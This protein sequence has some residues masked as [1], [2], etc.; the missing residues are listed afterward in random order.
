[1]KTAIFVLSILMLLWIGSK[2]DFLFGKKESI[3]VKQ[4]PL[5]DDQLLDSVQYLT[6]Q[7]FWKGSE[8]NSG[9]APERIHMNNVY[10]E[11]DKHIIATGG[12]GFGIMGMLA[13]CERGFISRDQLLNRL[14]QVVSFLEKAERFHGAYPHW[15]NGE[16]GK[17]KPFTPKDNGGD[18]VETAYLFQGLLAV[19]QYYLTGESREKLMGKRKDKLWR[20]VEWKWYQNRKPVLYW[21]WSPNYGWEMNFPIEGYNECLIAYVLGASSPTYPIS[22]DAYHK[23]WARNGKIVGHHEKYGYTLVLNHNYS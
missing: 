12:S 8:P 4:H 21:H 13:A 5:T 1:M 15:I 16:T 20:E 2:N 7:Y 6:F 22:P 19:K 23:G 14:T 10:P 18:I 17:V 11:N 9:L 3:S